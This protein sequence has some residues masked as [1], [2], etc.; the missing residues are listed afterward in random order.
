MSDDPQLEASPSFSEHQARQKQY[1]ADLAE[2][3]RAELRE[4][5]VSL[6]GASWKPAAVM[7]PIHECCRIDRAQAEALVAVA[8]PGEH[9][10]LRLALRDLVYSIR[11]RLADRMAD[12]ADITADTAGSMPA[13]DTMGGHEHEQ[14]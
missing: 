3:D 13:E 8:A 4:R 10:A 14:V 9:H 7:A 2:L 1:Q 5:F 11:G 12:V 6:A